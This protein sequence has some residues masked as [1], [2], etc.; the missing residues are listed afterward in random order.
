MSEPLT[1][2]P[3]SAIEIQDAARASVPPETQSNDAEAEP[4]VTDPPTQ[5]T[6]DP[7]LAAPVPQQLHFTTNYH[8]LFPTLA[9]L[10]EKGDYQEL[11]RLAER[12]DLSGENDEHVSRLLITAPL[13]LSYLV[14]DNLPSAR[15]SL[16]RLP[17]ALAKHPLSIALLSLQSAVKDKQYEHVY[18]CA[19]G[20]LAVLQKEALVPEFDLASLVAKLV[21]IFIETFQQKTFALLSKAY[22]SIPVP[23]AQVYL[24]LP[25]DQLLTIAA[26]HRWTYD[27]ST[28]ILSPEALSASSHPSRNVGLGSSLATFNSLADNLIIESN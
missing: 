16:T 12:G 22:S 10:A 3:S 5:E 26:R 4:I 28:Q 13:V 17:F 24:G 19:A 20:V 21:H 23:L 2:P 1:P 18:T 25:T 6:A 14:L 9:E 15:F 11:A 27:E 8:F 7:S